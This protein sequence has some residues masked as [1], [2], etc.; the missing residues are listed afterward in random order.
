MGND[1]EIFVELVVVVCKCIEISVVWRGR[2]G[3][4]CL[5]LNYVASLCLCLDHRRIP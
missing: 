2:F 4:V 3:K 5:L 1:L